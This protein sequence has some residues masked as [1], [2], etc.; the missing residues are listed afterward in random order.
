VWLYL[1]N[2]PLFA[3]AADTLRTVA[4]S[5]AQ[6]PG[7]DNGVTFADFYRYSVPG[8]LVFP[9]INNLGQ[10]A[11]TGSITGTGV[12]DQSSKAAIAVMLWCFFSVVVSDESKRV[13]HV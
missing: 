1:S 13:R 12:N 4:I 5:G 8:Q 9:V 3:A 6:T 11:F 2:S 7:T 10:V